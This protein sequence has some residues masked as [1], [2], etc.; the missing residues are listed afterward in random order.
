MDYSGTLG[1]SNGSSIKAQIFSFGTPQPSE[2]IGTAGNDRLIGTSVADVI[3]GLAGN[4]ILDGR[5]GDDTL[6]GGTGNDTYLVVSAGDKLVEK[7][8]EGTD[9]VKTAL[10]KYT[11]GLNLENLTFIDSGAHTGVGSA[12]ANRIIGGGGDDRLD[13]R[14]GTDRLEGGAGNDTYVVNVIGDRVIEAPGAGTDTLI[15][16][17]SFTLAANVEKLTLSGTSAINGTGNAN[18]NTITGNGADNILRGF[19]GIDKLIGGGGNDTLYGGIGRDLLTGGSGGDAFV[20]DTAFDATKTFDKVTD[21]VSGLDKLVFDKTVFSAFVATGS[22][23]MEAF[24]SGAGVTKA[25]DSTDRIVYN[26]TSGMLWYDADGN[27]SGKAVQVA[28]L[29]THP[30]LAFG[31]ILIVA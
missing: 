8:E 29:D 23:G 21:F 18:D 6:I 17:V 31:D 1:D 9:T 7:A 16:S 14:G 30:E 19:G 4:D 22:M 12:A 5:L 13:G 11:L 25:H 20:F 2:I 27:G 28:V 24:Y 10:A 3:K 26:T 15:A